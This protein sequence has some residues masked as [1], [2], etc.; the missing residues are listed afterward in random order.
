MDLGT[1]CTFSLRKNNNRQNGPLGAPKVLSEGPSGPS[2]AHLAPF[3]NLG[4]SLG[5]PVSALGAPRDPSKSAQQNQKRHWG[6]P[7]GCQ[8]TYFRCKHAFCE[9]AKKMNEKSMCA[10]SCSAIVFGGL[11]NRLFGR[12]GGPKSRLQKFMSEKRGLKISEL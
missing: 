6:P 5:P 8:P 11:Q 9:K 1:R 4:G 10:K 12:Q 2:V 3:R 7:R